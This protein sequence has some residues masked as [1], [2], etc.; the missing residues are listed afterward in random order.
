MIKANPASHPS[1]DERTLFRET[2]RS[3]GGGEDM[4]LAG[5]AVLLGVFLTGFLGV[6][7]LAVRQSRSR[8]SST[9][10]PGDILMT[11]IATY[12]VSRMM[13]R[14][15]VL[16]P[17]RAPFTRFEKNAGRSEVEE[18]SRGQGLSRAIGHLVTCPFCLSPWVATGLTATYL[19][20]PVAERTVTAIA[21]VV[22]WAD[23]LQVVHGRSIG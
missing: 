3:Y 21:S 18:H 2:A 6:T 16:A 19:V 17:L 14:D 13:A 9:P 5:H 22:A 15:K 12:K 8:K 1:A 4:P 11:G 23:V 20:S 7:A 10:T